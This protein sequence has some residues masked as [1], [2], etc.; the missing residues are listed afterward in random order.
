MMKDLLNYNGTSF[1][2]VLKQSRTM[3][4]HFVISLTNHRIDFLEWE[5]SNHLKIEFSKHLRP[6]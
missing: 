6:A 5:I 4:V 2:I 1:W 3:I